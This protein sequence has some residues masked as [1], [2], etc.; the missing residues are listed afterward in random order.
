MK[1]A[2]QRAMQALVS[3]GWDERTAGNMDFGYTVS[4]VAIDGTEAVEIVYLDADERAELRELSPGWYLIHET[5]TGSV[6][7]ERVGQEELDKVHDAM[8][9]LDYAA[10]G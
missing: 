2:L 10:L 1:T 8:N 4:L 7:V 5:D 3:G 9:E 6:N